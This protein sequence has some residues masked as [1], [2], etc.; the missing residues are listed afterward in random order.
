MF[1]SILVPLNSSDRSEHA[2]PVALSLAR[3]TD[4]QLDIVLVHEPDM[5]YRCDLNAELKWTSEQYLHDLASY[6]PWP[7]HQRS[8]YHLCEGFVAET[9]EAEIARRDIG[10]VVM[11]TARPC[12][13]A[14]VFRH[15]ISDW[16]VQRSS[17]P[18]LLVQP[19]NVPAR[20]SHPASYRRILVPL[21]G[22]ESLEEFV[23]ISR[24]LQDPEEAGYRLLRVLSP[25]SPGMAR[26]RAGEELEEIAQKLRNA[27][28]NVRIE[29]AIHP[30]R[31]AAI[32]ADARNAGCD[33]IMQVGLPRRGVLRRFFFGSD[34]KQV[35]G[36][37]TT[38]LSYMPLPTVKEIEAVEGLRSSAA[39][40][41]YRMYESVARPAVEIP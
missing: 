13:L 40:S 4:A 1:R 10:L 14:Q 5:F 35:A 36:D 18:V 7:L 11:T 27:R 3:K 26:H 19:P 22:T 8:N 16:L 6:L 2:L 38:A 32:Q 41:S 17:A 39:T 33:A 37:T 24:A 30:D 12:G 29:V 21:D 9:L 15:S 25:A 23:A 28:T 34:P 31:A 20:L